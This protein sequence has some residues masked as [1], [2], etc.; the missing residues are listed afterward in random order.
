MP[1]IAEQVEDVGQVQNHMR[2]LA[3]M[4]AWMERADVVRT[5]LSGVDAIVR[6]YRGM[7]ETEGWEPE[8]HR[9]LGLAR[10]QGLVRARCIL[11]HSR[12]NIYRNTMPGW[13]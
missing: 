4:L 13:S 12:S 9:E 8:G 5:A 11:T 3:Q 6:R 7:V 2:H 10:D 1:F